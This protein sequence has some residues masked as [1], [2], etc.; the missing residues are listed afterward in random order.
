MQASLSNEKYFSH[1]NFIAKHRLQCELNECCEYEQNFPFIRDFWTNSFNLNLLFKL[2]SVQMQSGGNFISQDLP[3]SRELN[4]NAPRN[5][6]LSSF[7]KKHNKKP[8]RRSIYFP[9]KVS[10]GVLSCL[11]V[12][13]ASSIWS[14]FRSRFYEENIFLCAAG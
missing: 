10:F 1:G 7:K 8:S 4:V 9:P 3:C 2:S 13:K 6:L 14:V 11:A 5:R 12:L